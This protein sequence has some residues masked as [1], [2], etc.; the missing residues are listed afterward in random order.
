[1]NTVAPAIAVQA[2]RRTLSGTAGTWSGSSISYTYSW[3]RCNLTVTSC[4]DVPGA[5]S[6]SY[7]LSTVDAGSR[8]RLR[9]TGTNP[10]GKASATSQ[11]TAVVSSA[12]RL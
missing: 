7:A 9:V 12:G 6:P 11:P 2:D 4:V 10:G 8:L 3:S 5:A 1:M